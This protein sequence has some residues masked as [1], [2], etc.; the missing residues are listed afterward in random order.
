MVAHAIGEGTRAL[1]EGTSYEQKPLVLHCMGSSPEALQIGS[2]L[3]PE[4]RG[5]APTNCRG[6]SG[7]ETNTD[8][9]RRPLPARALSFPKVPASPPDQVTIQKGP[10]CQGERSR[11]PRQKAKPK[12]AVE[13]T[14]QMEG[15]K[16]AP[17]QTKD[18]SSGSRPGKAE[19]SFLKVALKFP[20]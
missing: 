6:Q 3:A 9:F 13:Q 17:P 4:K 8:S 19:A 11:S 1:S 18:P 12:G 7:T 14:I 2:C 16:S 5:E 15:S 20:G 10:T